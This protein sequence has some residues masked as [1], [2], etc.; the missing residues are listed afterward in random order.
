MCVTGDGRRD[1]SAAPSARGTEGE[2]GMGAFHGN[3]ETSQ[4]LRRRHQLPF[5]AYHLAPRDIQLTSTTTSVR[6]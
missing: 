1:V 4:K 5:P 3:I 2:K 6:F